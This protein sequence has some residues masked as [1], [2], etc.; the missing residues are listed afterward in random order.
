M[1]ILEADAGLHFLLQVKTQLRDAE[2]SARLENNLAGNGRNCIACESV[3]YDTLCKSK[4]LII[5]I[6]SDRRQIV[7]LRI[8]EEVIYED[9]RALNQLRLAR[10]QLLVDLAKGLNADS[11]AVALGKILALVLLKGCNE[12]RILAEDAVNVL[13]RFYKEVKLIVLVSS[14]L[15]TVNDIALLNDS[16]GADEH[17]QGQLTVLVDANVSHAVYIGLVFEPGAA[18]RNDLRRVGALT[19]LVY[20]RGIVHSRRSDDLRNDNTLGTVDNEGS[21]LGHKREIALVYIGLLDLTGLLVGQ[22]DVDLERCGVVDVAL[23]ALL[24]GILRSLINRE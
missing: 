17:S 22:S 7:A 19:G 13:A 9:L 8:K 21:V 3:S 4:L 14:D 18:V 11:A 16:E 10:T 6:A 1:T 2:L 24:D 15:I 20:I 23:L 12:D 5:L